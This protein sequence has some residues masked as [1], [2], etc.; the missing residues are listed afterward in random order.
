M[1]ATKVFD[2]LTW[3]DLVIKHCTEHCNK[4]SSKTWYPIRHHHFN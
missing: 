3:D 2:D 1:D 4:W